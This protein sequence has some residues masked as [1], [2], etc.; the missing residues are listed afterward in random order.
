MF[1]DYYYP[2][3]GM[4]RVPDVLAA[5]GYQQ[6]APSVIQGGGGSPGGPGRGPRFF[7]PRRGAAP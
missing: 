7:S 1:L 3:G 5:A 2:Q 6:I 4:Q